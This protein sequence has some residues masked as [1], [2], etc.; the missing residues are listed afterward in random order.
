MTAL[1]AVR[2]KTWHLRG[3]KNLIGETRDIHDDTQSR[4][5]ILSVVREPSNV[6]EAPTRGKL[7]FAGGRGFSMEACEGKGRGHNLWTFWLEGLAC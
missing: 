2:D 7:L 1:G 5:N 6:G 3:F 4:L